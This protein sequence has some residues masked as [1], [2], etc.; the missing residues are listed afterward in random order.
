MKQ[1]VYH[2]WFRRKSIGQQHV[3]A[4]HAENGLNM[5][6]RKCSGIVFGDA[7]KIVFDFS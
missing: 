1:L 7:G 4:A 3:F 6:A 5:S 2:L